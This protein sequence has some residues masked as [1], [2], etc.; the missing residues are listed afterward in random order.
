V[1]ATGWKDAQKGKPVI[2]RFA[3]VDGALPRRDARD[4]AEVV[5]GLDSGAHGRA[6]TAAGY[7][8]SLKEHREWVSEEAQSMKARAKR[9]K[10]GEDFASMEGDSRLPKVNPLHL[11]DDDDQSAEGMLKKRYLSPRPL[12]HK[13]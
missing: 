3:G 2:E 8:Q 11:L 7:L 5:G 12:S 10:A 1:A 9:A 6:L 13:P 4:G